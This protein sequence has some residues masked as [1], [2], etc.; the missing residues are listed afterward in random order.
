MLAMFGYAELVHPSSLP[1]LQSTWGSYWWDS[2]GVSPVRP[3]VILCSGT[4]GSSRGSP[5]LWSG[6]GSTTH[7][8][9]VEP[10]WL[11]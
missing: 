3:T 7:E 11:T 4:A 10:P 8:A 1:S 6:R 5:T 9:G 2:G